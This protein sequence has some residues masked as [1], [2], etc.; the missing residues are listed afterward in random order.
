[1][2]A[3]DARVG[4]QGARIRVRPEGSREEGGDAHRGGRQVPPLQQGNLYK[5]TIYIAIL[6]S[7][8]IFKLC[9][10]ILELQ[11][12]HKTPVGL[13][14]QGMKNNFSLSGDMVI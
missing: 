8:T 4:V 1:M 9:F 5:T 12:E 13:V 10:Q 7:F 14:A 2:Q 6:L 11:P 3:G